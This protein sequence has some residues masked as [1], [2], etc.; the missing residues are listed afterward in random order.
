MSEL[1][2]HG[3]VVKTGSSTLRALLFAAAARVHTPS[4]AT[5][6]TTGLASWLCLRGVLALNPLDFQRHCPSDSEVVMG[7]HQ[8]YGSGRLIRPAHTLRRGLRLLTTLREPLDRSVSEYTYMCLRCQ[9]RSLFCRPHVGHAHCPNQ[10]SFVEWIR[11]VPNQFTRQFARYW[12]GNSYFQSYVRGFAGHPRVTPRDVDAAFKTLSNPRSFVLW[13]DSMQGVRQCETLARLRAWLG[14]D[15]SRALAA[16]NAFPHANALP[17][18]SR[19]TPTPEE[20][21]EACEVLWADCALYARLRPNR[22]CAC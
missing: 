16:V 5:N 1:V 9:D 14:G 10:T 12:L 20:R 3:Q 4:V 21:R 22:T 17:V 6:T 11:Y 2:V 8:A 13:T 18:A 7:S 19:Y 15:A